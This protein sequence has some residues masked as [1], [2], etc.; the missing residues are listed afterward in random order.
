MDV[1]SLWSLCARSVAEV[2]DRFRI[3]CDGG[4]SLVGR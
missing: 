2:S 4:M 3:G 1:E